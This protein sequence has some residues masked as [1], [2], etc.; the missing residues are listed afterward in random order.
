MNEFDNTENVPETENYSGY[1][2]PSGTFETGAY[3]NRNTSKPESPYADSPYSSYSQP[4]PGSGY[5]RQPEY[6][7]TP[8]QQPAYT[9]KEPRKRGSL[10]KALLSFVLVI[11]LVAG[12][13]G[14]TAFAVNNRWERRNRQTVDMMEQQIADLR[15]QIDLAASSI[16]SSSF[17][18]SPVSNSDYLTPGQ[19]YAQNV[20]KVVSI[21]STVRSTSFGR[22]TEGTATGSGFILT[23]NG[24]IATNY[25]VI[26]DA[27]SVSVTTYS[28]DVYSAEVVGYD[29]ASDL[30]VLKVD[31]ENLPA[32]TLGSSESLKI[33]DMV[34]AIGNPLGELTATQTVGYV[35]GKN[36]EVT[37]DNNSISMIQTDAAI[38]P[39]NSGGPLFNMKGEVVGITTAKYS[40][41]TSGGATIEG[42][43]FAIPMD[44]IANIIKDLK[45]L[46][47]VTGAYLGV[48][49]QDTDAQAAAQ[50]GLPTGAYVATTVEGGSADRAGVQP[51]DII[52]GLGDYTVGSV[53]DLTR[54]L[55]NFK[56]GDIT[57]ITVIRSGQQLV[58][59]ITLDEK[60]QDLN[61]G[62][63]SDSS[64]I[65]P[66]EGGYDEWYDYFRRFF[67]YG[68]M[69]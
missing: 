54:A 23:E 52:I 41:T 50:Y 32:V 43:G 14:I 16:E 58:M 49:V 60:P 65:V 1:S 6:R 22:V 31:A 9:P 68:G 13:C 24:Y 46:G 56:A 5:Y 36:R 59:E 62:S 55:R 21:A 33:G 44:D 64:P 15:K 42:I 19:V 2:A 67:E 11:A 17:S 53:S 45:D 30:A 8:N 26:Q 57:Q 7:Y 20:N 35:S 38:N 66:D 47:Y 63:N 61:S 10:G 25:H 27:V 37:T 40:G 4:Q 34:V 3:Q 51:K 69:G 12:G 29:A 48:T 18:G 39:G 28:D